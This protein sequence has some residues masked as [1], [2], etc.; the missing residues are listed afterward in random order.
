MSLTKRPKMEI[1]KTKS[2]W[3][4]DI[5]GYI[6]LAFMVI[7]LFMNWRELP[8]EVPVHFDGS[9]NVDRWGS[10]WELLILPGI[11]IAMHFFLKIFEKFPETHNYPARINESNAEVFYR[12]SRQTLNYMRNILNILFAYIV[13]RTIAIA[14]EEA[15]TIG[16]PFFIILAALFAVLIWK[17][18][19]IFRIK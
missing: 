9:G 16:W 14:L 11:G 12:N 4:M 2:E 19:R 17:M 18:V 1:P 5:I 10:K 8:N 15:T 13:Y 6:V 3:L 7:V